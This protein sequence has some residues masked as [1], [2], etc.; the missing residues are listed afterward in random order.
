[1]NIKEE[2]EDYYLDE[3]GRLTYK[4]EYHLHRG[5]CCFNFCLHCPY[6]TTVEKY[7]LKPTRVDSH[8]IQF[9]LKGQTCAIYNES[10][11]QGQ[12]WEIYPRFK[13]QQLEDDLN[14]ALRTFYTSKD[15]Q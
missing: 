1:M 4:A 2:T 14:S 11:E 10:T 3:N 15:G 7:G 13:T 8:N 12:N 9:S 5:D 6:G